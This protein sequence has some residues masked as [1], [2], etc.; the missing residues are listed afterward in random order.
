MFNYELKVKL[1]NSKQ[2]VT[3]RLQSSFFHAMGVTGESSLPVAEKMAKRSP[4]QHEHYTHTAP[5]IPSSTALSIFFFLLHLL[6]MRLLFLLL[7]LFQ[8]FLHNLLCFRPI[9]HFQ[10]DLLLEIARTPCPE[11]KGLFPRTLLITYP[12]RVA[13]SSSHSRIPY[14]GTESCRTVHQQVGFLFLLLLFLLAP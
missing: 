7:V 8:D 6:L 3:N 13:P 12:L 10:F 5:D 4:M 9:L 11:S 1:W 2:Q 14:S